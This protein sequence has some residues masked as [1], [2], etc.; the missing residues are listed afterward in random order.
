MHLRSGTPQAWQ[1]SMLRRQ[2]GGC[3]WL[4]QPP[5]NVLQEG[6]LRLRRHARR[7]EKESWERCWTLQWK[8]SP[9]LCKS[10]DCK[11]LR[12]W[13]HMWREEEEPLGRKS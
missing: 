10:T 3:R 8:Q 6:A 7:Q 4:Q 5:R 13:R 1:P 11:K 9:K 2:V 12:L